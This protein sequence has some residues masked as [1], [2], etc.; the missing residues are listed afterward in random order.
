MGFLFSRPLVLLQVN[1]HA[2]V[3]AAEAE[4][5]IEREILIV[6]TQDD[7]VAARLARQ[8]NQRP[9]DG[10]A[11]ALAP[12]T[13]MDG[14]IFNVPD[15]P[16][17]M[18][19]LMFKN[20]AGGSQDVSIAIDG[21][22]SPNARRVSPTPDANGLLRCQIDRGQVGQRFQEATGEISLLEWSQFKRHNS[23]LG[24]VGVTMVAN[25]RSPVESASPACPVRLDDISKT[26]YAGRLD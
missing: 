24:R 12:M 16:A 2:V 20:Q 10:R 25:A 7:F 5:R 21:D 11:D 15:R 14:D 22:D 13:R 26:G 23:L 1:S 6:A 4:A 9:H 17:A 19:E 8:F 3:V 18:D